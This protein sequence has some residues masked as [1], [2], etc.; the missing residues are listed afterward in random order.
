M[1]RQM[2]NGWLSRGRPSVVHPQGAFDVFSYYQL[3]MLFLNMVCLTVALAFKFPLFLPVYMQLTSHSNP[4]GC[5]VDRH[6]QTDSKLSLEV[7]QGRLWGSLRC[8]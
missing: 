5:E 6:L 8:R 7:D 1:I 2:L 3:V 4:V